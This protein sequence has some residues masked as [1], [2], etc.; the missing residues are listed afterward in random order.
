VPQPIRGNP[1]GLKELSHCV[2][3]LPLLSIS[4]RLQYVQ[5]IAFTRR[6]CA[7]PVLKEIERALKKRERTSSSAYRD[8][9]SASFFVLNGLVLSTVDYMVHAREALRMSQAPASWNFSGLFFCVLSPAR[10]YKLSPRLA[11]AIG[12]AASRRPPQHLI[13]F[14][15]VSG[16]SSR[17]G[18][19]RAAQGRGT[20]NGVHDS[21][22][23]SDRGDPLG[24]F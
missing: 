1:V 10:I 16:R 7:I 4:L 21:W 24:R 6:Q 18:A 14:A 20:A 12:A 23:S 19:W 2:P 9:C 15:K 11:L 8:H 3:R 13:Q 17:R 5:D 22:L